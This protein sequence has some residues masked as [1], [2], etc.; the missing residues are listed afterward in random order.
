[1]SLWSNFCVLV[2]AWMRRGPINAPWGLRLWPSDLRHMIENAPLTCFSLLMR[3]RMDLEMFLFPSVQ[4]WWFP[5]QRIVSAIDNP[6]NVTR[7]PPVS[8]QDSGSTGL[9]GSVS[10]T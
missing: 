4:L 9:S 10:S 1:M 6:R 3:A 5:A 2:R 8:M 7:Q